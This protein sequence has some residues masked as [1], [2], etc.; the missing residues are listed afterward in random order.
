MEGVWRVVVGTGGSF[1]V[2]PEGQPDAVLPFW[3]GVAFEAE[4]WE[5]WAWG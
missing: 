4:G 3:Q 1:P 2:R 5:G